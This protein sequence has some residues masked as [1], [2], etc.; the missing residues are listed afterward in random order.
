MKIKTTTERLPWYT[1]LEK[2]NA[3]NQILTPASLSICLSLS[4][5]LSLP[6]CVRVSE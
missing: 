1:H 6:L 2:E 5:C 4:V 3:I